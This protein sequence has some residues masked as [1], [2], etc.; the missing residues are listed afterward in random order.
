MAETISAIYVGATSLLSALGDRD[1]SLVAIRRGECGL[2]WSAQYAMPVGAIPARHPMA[3]PIAGLTRFESLMVRQIEA[4]CRAAALTL[5]DDGVQLILS[6]TKG[7][8]A[9]LAD[10]STI[11]DEA[12]LAHTAQRIVSYLGGG[13]APILISNACISGLSAMVVARNLLLDGQCRHVIVAGGDELSEFITSGFASFKSISEQPC[14]P[15]DAERDGLTLGEACGALLLT[16]DRSRA[17]E[18]VVCLA[19]GAVTNDANHISG[20]SRTGDGLYYAIRE[21][22]QEAGVTADEVGMVNPHGTATRYND[23]M[24]SKALAWAGLSEVPTAGLKGY[25]GHTLGASGVVESILSVEAMRGGELFATQGFRVSDTPCPLQVSGA[26][27]P[28]AKPCCVKTASG[29]GGCNAAVVL[30]AET[31]CRPKPLPT[32]EVQEGATYAMASCDAPFAAY[33]RERF[34]ALGAPN[35]K[36]YKMSDLAKGLYVA[37]ETLLAAEPAWAEVEPTRRALVLANCSSSLEA[38][39]AHQKEVNRHAPEGTSPALFVYT[40]P[41]VAAGEMCIRHQI[42]GDNTFFIETEDTGAAEAYGRLLIRQGRADRVVCGWAEKLGEEW[43]YRLK[44]L[45]QA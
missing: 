4:V 30:L 23:E 25:I 12:F 34:K 29:F 38:D 15:Y 14:R 27:Q 19:G 10:H 24:E 40:L 1:E 9:S 28:I 16:C 41:N 21:A 35:M 18:P 43:N 33:I 42:Q 7:N 39:W 11:P 31:M 3:E 45:Q 44:L 20:P 8:V 22:L 17:E 5:A 32:K 37:M 36:F 26:T 13:R 2:G 6:T